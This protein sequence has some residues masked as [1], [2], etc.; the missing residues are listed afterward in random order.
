MQLG[1]LPRAVE[2]A[3]RALQYT[4]RSGAT[5]DLVKR[6]VNLAWLLHYEGRTSEARQGFGEALRLLKKYR[7]DQPRLLSTQGQRYGEF[8]LEA[9]P[10]LETIKEAAAIGQG[11]IDHPTP[12]Y[13]TL[14]PAMGY[15][16]RGRAESLLF[17]LGQ[18]LDNEAALHSL[19]QAEDLSRQTGHRDAVVRCLLPLAAA[20]RLAG[21]FQDAVRYLT[22]VEELIEQY[23]M[24]LYR[25]DCALERAWLALARNDEAVAIEFLGQAK[26]FRA[27]YAPSYGRYDHTFAELESRCVRTSK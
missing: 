23:G 8:L 19:K 2:L 20:S 18:S 26:E 16:I 21:R 14:D 22:E 3:T 13:E 12:V 9:D 17:S 1:D 15:A 10:T 5:Q 25:I 4:E 7:P 24:Y 27:R 6:H 11:M